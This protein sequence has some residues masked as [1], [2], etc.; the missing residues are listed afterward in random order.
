MRPFNSDDALRCSFTKDVC[1]FR[2]VNP[3]SVPH[4][5][6][7]VMLMLY[8]HH[9]QLLQ[10][11]FESTIAI[12]ML[13]QHGTSFDESL[14]AALQS[15]KMNCK[16]IKERGV[17]QGNVALLKSLKLYNLAVGNDDKDSNEELKRNATSMAQLTCRLE[18]N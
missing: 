1:S 10:G 15:S 17:D 7:I 18:S 5:P 8:L 14:L 9:H 4:C 13:K 12:D 2:P 3:T 6:S 11:G 16:E